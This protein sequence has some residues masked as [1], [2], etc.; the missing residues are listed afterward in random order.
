MMVYGMCRTDG[1]GGMRII[2][3]L[4][5]GI[6]TAITIFTIAS[7]LCGLSVNTPTMIAAPLLQEM[8]GA[9]MM[10]VGRLPLSAPG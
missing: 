3:A 1:D 2:P 9:M 10:P 8:G 6:A 5:A 7:V 4:F